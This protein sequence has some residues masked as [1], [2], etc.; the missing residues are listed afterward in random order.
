MPRIAIENGTS[1]RCRACEAIWVGFKGIEPVQCPRCKSLK[2]KTVPD[3]QGT[4]YAKATKVKRAK[5]PKVVFGRVERG[6]LEPF[7]S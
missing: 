4:V 1:H 3:L 5:K 6:D 2:W 7:D